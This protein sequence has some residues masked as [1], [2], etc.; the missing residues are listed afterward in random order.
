ML[1]GSKV[2]IT[3]T[4]TSKGQTTV[5]KEILEQLGLSSGD[6][7]EYII[8][9]DGR[10]VMLPATRQIADLSGTLKHRAGTRPVTLEEMDEAIRT[11]QKR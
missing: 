7:I 3:S 9:A 1:N 2:V 6:R 4:L 8:E 5:P 11:R 10:V